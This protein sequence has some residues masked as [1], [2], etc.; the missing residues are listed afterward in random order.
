MAA[1]DGKSF[2]LYVGDAGSPQSFVLVGGF[3]SNQ[4]TINEELVDITNK[5]STGK[6]RELGRF[7]IK[8]ASIS[9][10]GVFIDSA[11]EETVRGSIMTE[12]TIR[13]YQIVFP[14]FGTFEGEFL[15]TNLTYN[16]PQNAAI[17]YSIS[18]ESNGQLD[19][20]AS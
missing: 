14:D 7:G 11:G 17:T 19:F 13:N 10:D 1:Q 4:L 16:G 5:S 8:T 15:I 12:T 3:Q 18:L 20:V 2:L 6:W 9:G